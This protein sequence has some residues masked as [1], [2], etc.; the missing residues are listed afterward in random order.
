[1]NPK[2]QATQQSIQNMNQINKVVNP[3]REA[4]FFKDYWTKGFQ[5]GRFEERND[6][7]KP[8]A[9]FANFLTEQFVEAPISAPKTIAEGKSE[10]EKGRY[11]SGAGKIGTGVVDLVSLIPIFKAGKLATTAPKLSKVITASAKEGAAYGGGYGL[12]E[13]LIQAQDAKPEDRL[14]I[15]AGSTLQ[16]AGGGA[17]LGA[18]IPA[19]TGALKKTYKYF[20]PDNLLEV[21]RP[22]D[23]KLAPILKKNDEQRN[24]PSVGAVTPDQ[25]SGSVEL[26]TIKTQVPETK[27]QPGVKKLRA[28]LPY[29]KKDITEGNFQNKQVGKKIVSDAETSAAQSGKK[30]PKV[31]SIV[32]SKAEDII[33]NLAAG[34]TDGADE[35]AVNLD[36]ETFGKTKKFLISLKDNGNLSDEAKADLGDYIDTLDAKYTQRESKKEFDYVNA[37]INELSSEERE[38]FARSILD[39]VNRVNQYIYNNGIASSDRPRLIQEAIYQAYPKSFTMYGNVEEFVDA[40]AAKYASEGNP[41]YKNLFSASAAIRTAAGQTIESAKRSLQGQ[42]DQAQ[43]A[44]NILRGKKNAKLNTEINN[45]SQ[46]ISDE[47]TNQVNTLLDSGATQKQVKKFVNDFMTEKFGKDWDKAS[48]PLLLKE[49]APDT[50]ARR[51]EELVKRIPKSAAEVKEQNVIDAM[52]RQLYNIAKDEIKAPLN[53]GNP[54]SIFKVLKTALTN[55]GKYKKTWEKAK[56]RVMETFKNDEEAYAILQDYF[57]RTVPDVFKESQAQR[58]YRRLIK[59]SDISFNDLVRQHFSNQIAKREDLILKLQAKLGISQADAATLTNKFYGYFNANLQDARKAAVDR[60]LKPIVKNPKQRKEAIDKIIE[61]SNL[62]IFNNA[63]Y[64]NAVASKLGLPHL[65]DENAQFIAKTM[66]RLQKGEIDMETALR[67]IAENI[68]KTSGFDP[69]KNPGDFNL[70]MTSY[71]YNNIF[72][73]FQT[74]ERNLL[75]GLVNAFVVRPATIAGERIAGNIFRTLGKELPE[76]VKSLPKGELGQYYKQLFGSIGQAS[77][78]FFQVISDPNFIARTDNPTVRYYF[79]K[80]RENQLPKIMTFVGRFM[81]AMDQFNATLIMNAEENLM[82]NRG[83]SAEVA[84]QKAFAT[85]QELLGR[86]SFGKGFQLSDFTDGK[87]KTKV[88]QEGWIDAFFDTIGNAGYKLRGKPGF[89]NLASTAIFPVIRIAINLQKLKTKLFLP[90]QV[91]NVLSKDP[92]NRKLQDYGYLVASSFTTAYAI[93]KMMKGEIEF[94]A[95]RDEKAKALFYDAGKKPYSVKIG[96]SYVPFQYLEVFGAPF[97]AMGAIKAAFQDNPDAL[98]QSTID[99][100]ALALWKFGRSYFVSPTYLSTLANIYEASANINGKDWKQALAYPA[101]GLI[102]FSGLLRDLSDIIDPIRRQKKEGWDEFKSVFAPLR[103]DLEPFRSSELKPVELNASELYA[104]YGIGTVNEQK[105]R[106][107]ERRVQEIQQGKLR[108]SQ[109]KGEK[110]RIDAAKTELEMALRAG[111]NKYANQVVINSKLTPSEVTSVTNKIKEDQ[112]KSK[113]S[114]EELGLYNLTSQQLD[115]LGQQNP[116]LKPLINKV[117]SFKKDFESPTQDVFQTLASINK[118]ATTKKPRVKKVR[119]RKARVKKVRAKKMRVAK[120]K[121]VTTPKVKKL[122]AIKTPKV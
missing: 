37:S 18:A 118:P 73:S 71:F 106:E 54:D 6:F 99:K 80:G 96:D 34:N 3:G 115:Y 28:K 122:T 62:G 1:M 87:W 72:S 22:L 59:E 56:Q 82:R 41:I 76:G 40:L 29:I 105:Q 91:L 117:S 9:Q 12:F 93:D 110:E 39:I 42:V 60:I 84:R 63:E 43:E 79:D 89:L 67:S 58:A 65:S 36:I 55:K 45:V 50:V 92:A 114:V 86:G 109:L 2:D 57:G 31:S 30:L 64:A 44:L 77:N 101:T 66:D 11:Y 25:P 68:S 113:L 102:P 38:S 47:F 7:F 8:V 14:G 100:V 116:E 119:G 108:Q 24:K 112:A 49:L 61:Y 98:T 120:G 13:G 75:G 21:T 20:F 78:R 97:L 107:Y 69:I 83:Y 19:A 85:S 27:G 4:T 53:S 74:W 16:G 111:D 32:K 52:I 90:T 26:P 35:I 70:F 23:D 48:K 17:L 46:E 95:P 88:S 15:I 33:T 103:Q 94:E 81:E 10:I 104:P 5:L 121:G 51:I